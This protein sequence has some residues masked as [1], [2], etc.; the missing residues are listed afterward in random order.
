MGQPIIAPQ[1]VSPRDDFSLRPPNQWGMHTKS[2]S[3]NAG[4]RR[5]HREPLEGIKILLSTVR[6]PRVIERVYTNEYVMSTQRLNPTEGQRQQH[7]V[8]RG[9]I[10]GRNSVSIRRLVLFD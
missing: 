1:S 2:S 10:R 7:G 4:L 6:L 3:L 8:P 5:Q 9:D